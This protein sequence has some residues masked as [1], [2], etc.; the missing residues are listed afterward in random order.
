MPKTH[1]GLIVANCAS[2]V[3]TTDIVASNG[4]ILVIDNVL[5]PAAE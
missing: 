4:V 2:N 5:L 1:S 3:V